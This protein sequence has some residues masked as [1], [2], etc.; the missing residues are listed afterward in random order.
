MAVKRKEKKPT[1][2]L[3]CVLG[4]YTRFLS[5]CVITPDGIIGSTFNL[6]RRGF[7]SL[8]SLR[9]EI[10]GRLFFKFNIEI[11]SY[12]RSRAPEN[13]WHGNTITWR[14]TGFL[15]TV[16]VS[17]FQEVETIRILP[18][19]TLPSPFRTSSKAARPKGN[20]CKLD[21]I[22]LWIYGFVFGRLLFHRNRQT[23]P[24]W[25]TNDINKTHKKK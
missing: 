19:A 15:A 2:L 4:F 3:V 13:G 11:F 7:V 24:N 12:Y 6:W 21:L 20:Y 17:P 10:S 23:G 8:F 9:F 14:W 18:T 5:R 16:S 22:F 25:L 1:N